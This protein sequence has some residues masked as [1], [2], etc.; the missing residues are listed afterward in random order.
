VR[1]IFV[2]FAVYLQQFITTIIYI[3][4]LGHKKTAPTIL[5][6]Q[7]VYY[8]HR[9]IA[10]HFPCDIM[11]Q[12]KPAANIL[13]RYSQ[14]IAHTM[15]QPPIVPHFPC[16]IMAQKKPAANILTRYSQLIAPT[17]AQASLAPHLRCGIMAQ[18][19]SVINR[20]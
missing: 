15:A 4:I 7:V 8:K 10:P 19:K 20:L 16:D 14:L 13:T 18:K 12:K 1:H 2:V 17:M 11:A 9:P 6:I 5:F 3:E